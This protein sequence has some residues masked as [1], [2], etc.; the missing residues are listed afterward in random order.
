LRLA[1]DDNE[2][3]EGEEADM[4][5]EAAPSELEHKPQQEKLQTLKHQ[6]EQERK[7]SDDYLTRLKYLQA[8]HE[9]YRMRMERELREMEDF[10]TA[11]LISKLLPVLDELELA[12]ATQRAQQQQEA[13]EEGEAM[14]RPAEHPAVSEGITMVLKN[15]MAVLQAEGVKP[16]EAIGM[17][18]DP[19]LHEAVDKVEGD[20]LGDDIVIEE[21]RRGYTF[22]HRLLRPS[23]VKVELGRRRTNKGN[24]NKEAPKEG[25]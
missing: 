16:I 12:S 23:L 25:A 17:Q 11:K 4:K 10:S 14:Q 9:N 20:R 8:D 24:E 1:E 21:I 22:R 15:M 13:S 6:L 2:N 19:K 3:V 18:F 7:K 5:Q